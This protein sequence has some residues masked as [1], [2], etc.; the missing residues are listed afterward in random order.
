MGT[1]PLEIERKFLLKK[2]P[3]GMFFDM[4]SNITQYYLPQD[5]NGFTVRIREVKKNGDTTCY[6]TKKKY[7]SPTVNEEIEKQI[8]RAEFNYLKGKA[9]TV[10]SK[11]RYIHHMDGL[12]W[13]I[14]V[15][16]GIKLIIAEIEL[17]SEDYE[18]EIPQGIEDV[19]IKEV[20]GI[21]EF[22]NQPLSEPV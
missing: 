5:E 12:L 13:E 7:V 6:L 1:T 20:S 21:K 15:F 22:Y 14:D 8:S 17:P 9:L 10:I 4:A 3:K 18:L 16:D 11:V 2:T 19:L